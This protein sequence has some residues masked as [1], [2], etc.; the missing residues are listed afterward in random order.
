MIKITTLRRHLNWPAERDQELE[1]LRDVVIDL[2]ESATMRLWNARTGHVEVISNDC[3]RRTIFLELWPITTITTVEEQKRDES[4]WEALDSDEF[5]TYL[6]HGLER[7]SGVNNSTTTKFEPNV[8]V[9]YDG[10]VTEASKDIQQA[11]CVQAAFM[12]ARFADEKVDMRSKAIKDAST[13]YEVANY[14]PF[15]R[16]MA[17]RHKRK[18]V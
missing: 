6:D 12:N 15:F 7:I 14:H 16:M 2:W 8:R 5:K 1:F 10:G 18:G 11:L 9:T 13:S 3:P 4:T 17:Q